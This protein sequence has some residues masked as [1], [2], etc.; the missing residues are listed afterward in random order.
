MAK[1]RS[2]RHQVKRKLASVHN[3]LEDAGVHLSWLIKI[4][5]EAHPD[6]AEA[7]ESLGYM[8][9]QCLV[10]IEEFWEVTQGKLPQDWRQAARE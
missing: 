8:I 5:K 2:T 10:M 4:H 1:G 6:L 7:L 3:N 9:G